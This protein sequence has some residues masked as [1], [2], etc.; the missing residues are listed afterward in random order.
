MMLMSEKLPTGSKPGGDDRERAAAAELAGARG[1]TRPGEPAGP[2]AADQP[3]DARRSWPP[4][5]ARRPCNRRPPWGWGTPA[6]SPPSSSVIGKEHQRAGD[7][8]GEHDGGRGGVARQRAPERGQSL[9]IQQRRERRQPPHGDQR[10]DGR[11][12]DRPAGQRAADRAA[13]RRRDKRREQLLGRRAF[14]IA[15]QAVEERQAGRG[16]GRGR[17]VGRRGRWQRRQRA[18]VG[19]RAVAERVDGG[20]RAI[21]ARPARRRRRR[22]P[23]PGAPP[24]AGY[25]AAR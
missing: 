3:A 5:S 24:A 6:R 9:G 7:V 18:R 21:R 15:R 20:D 1:S 17:A 22:A 19:T 13:Q 4:R 25:A 2:E 16:R 23:R 8:A 14:G 11:H 12:H 10:G